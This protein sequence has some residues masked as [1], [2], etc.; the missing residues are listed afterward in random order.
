MPSN[1]KDARPA[2]AFG[3]VQQS[4]QLVED[5]GGNLQ[6]PA[7][8]YTNTGNAEQPAWS[9]IAPQMIPYYY[10]GAFIPGHLNP[11]VP[12]TCEFEVVDAVVDDSGLPEPPRDLIKGVLPAGSKAVIQGACKTWKTWLDIL[13]AACVAVGGNWLGL[14]CECGKVLYVN[15][16][17]SAPRFMSRV[18][19]VVKALGADP[20]L[21]KQ[22]LKI[23]NGL[24]GN[25]T[26]GAFI[27]ALLEL[28]VV[29]DC[30]LVIIDPMYKIFEGNE[31]EQSAMSAFFREID[32]LIAASGCS[33]VVVHHY[34]KGFK[35]TWDI[36]DRS[37][38]SG[39]IG[40]DVD[41]LIDLC[42]IDGP[43]NAMRAS[44]VLR[45]YEERGPIEY[46]F[47]HPLCV[48]DDSGALSKCRPTNAHGGSGAKSGPRVSVD[49]LD[50]ICEELI[51]GKDKFN[52]ADLV[53]TL[54]YEKPGPVKKLLAQS[55]K[56]TEDVGSNYAH[57][58]RKLV[59]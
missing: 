47:D 7:N 55:S 28:D 27:D 20:D 24:N 44:F 32:R 57:V 23:V 51:D 41:A 40:R 1:E 54:N 56:F 29:K 38:G 11:K 25:R 15:L 46:W 21:I 36:A 35:G 19:A 17:L 43:G 53:K 13:L 3:H 49:E 58:V 52:R 12:P 10:P 45:D 9:S 50:A 37:S 14:G 6:A 16:E 22:N 18:L 33:V 34:S 2:D 31:N 8:N 30:K 48:A 42:R 59:S 26:I 5:G 4:G 39:V